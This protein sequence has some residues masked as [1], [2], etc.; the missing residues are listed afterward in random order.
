[1][2]RFI[3]VLVLIL[4]T[5]ACGSHESVVPVT[6]GASPTAPIPSPKGLFMRGTVYDTAFRPLA[7]ARVEVVDGPQ[8]GLSTSADTKGEFS[9]TGAF[10]D[11][12]RFRATKEGHVAAIKTLQPFCAA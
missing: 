2:S 11:A 8:A 3:A 4:G 5:A 1:M 12:T 9:L 10:D 7:G 6:T